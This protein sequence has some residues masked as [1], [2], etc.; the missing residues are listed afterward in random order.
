MT[1][2][3]Q[4]NT[5]SVSKKAVHLRLWLLMAA[6][7]FMLGAQAQGQAVQGRVID[8]DERK[9]IPNANVQLVRSN[10][11][12]KTRGTT[13]DV[14]GWF[15]VNKLRAATYELSVSF[16]G[17]ATHT[18]TIKVDK[19]D[20]NLP[21]IVLKQSAVGLKEVEVSE[22]VERVEQKGD[23]VQFNAA[24]FQTHQDATTEDLVKKMPGVTVDG[25][26][27]KVHG[28]EVKKVLVDGKQFFGDDPTVTLKNLPAEMVDKIQVFDKASDQSLFT[29][30]RDNNE[31]KTLNIVTRSDKREGTFGKIYAGIGPDEKYNAG[32]TL[33][34]FKGSSRVSLIGMSNNVNQ[35]N[36]SVSDIMSVMSNS[37]GSRGGGGGPGGRGGSGGSSLFS[38][39]QNGIAQTNAFGI[40]YIDKWS[41]KVQVSGNYFFNKTS[42]ETVSNAIRNYFT[43]NNLSYT[44]DSRTNTDNIN[45]RFNFRLEYSIDSMNSLIWVPRLT[46]QDNHAVSTVKTLSSSDMANINKNTRYETD[47]DNVGLQFV[48]DLTFLHKFKKE[49]RTVSV[50]FTGRL[51]KRDNDGT[52]QNTGLSDVYA[53]TLL[54]DQ[55]YNSTSNG[56]RLSGNLTYTEPIGKNGQLAISYKP[57]YSTEDAKKTSYDL[58]LDPTAMTTDTLLSNDYTN[59]NSSHRSGLNYRYRL[60]NW[61]FAAGAEFQQQS[62]T[63]KQTFPAISDISRS[64]NNILPSASITFRSKDAGHLNF[65]YRTSANNP[66]ISQLQPVPDLSNPQIVKTGNIALNPAYDHE[67]NLRTGKGTPRQA[68]HLYLFVNA[69]LTKDYIGN[70]TTLLRSD[71]LIN[72]YAVSKGSQLIVP[73]NLDSY[74]T[75][76]S[77]LVYSF[78]LTAIKS[79][80]NLN[81][82][83]TYTNSPSLLNDAFN[84]SH[85]HVYNG[86]F[87]LS[88]NIS[89]NLDF[90][91]AYNGSFNQVRNSLPSRPATDYYNHRITFNLT[92][93]FLERMVFSTDASQINYTGLS[94]SSNENYVLWN[95]YLGYKFLKN[96][97]LEAKISA[98]DILNQNLGIS[99]TVA[100]T[101]TE[102][103]QS[104]VLKQYAMV[105]LTWNL[106][107]F[108]N[109]GEADVREM[110]K[111]L[112]PPPGNMPPPGSMPPP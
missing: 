24:A 19:N 101:Y 16:V 27:V 73:V 96:K 55:T 37:G 39:Q 52:I 9:P 13:T 111:N 87:Y 77:F 76:R 62:I 48:N 70:A 17:Y 78:P 42:T 91:L 1:I 88:S 74:F 80:M 108:K 63:G 35:Q 81:A 49:G 100:E 56:T 2:K 86:G 22:V 75:A 79:N 89:K 29:G 72:G 31:E 8:A 36:F 102:D 45:H 60:N 66:T 3:Q 33:N 90:S 93:N 68:K 57:G 15:T 94:Q 46:I 26:T 85:N 83:Y 110:P 6:M 58:L 69:K 32:L 71:T 12:T 20:L 10:D 40:N 4:G 65:F 67:W 112:P 34:R 28:E 61:N 54:L 23:T 30:F 98:Y 38:G 82:G 103:V 97:S 53:D 14:N 5:F 59:N 109:G 105:T 51:D 104:N 84:R 95:A 43:S 99:R 7:A 106:K 11:N 25:T 41:E 47:I 64:Y 18:Q 44:E 107:Y 50:S 21:V 92:W